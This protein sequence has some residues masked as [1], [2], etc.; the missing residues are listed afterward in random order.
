MNS[1][2]NFSY[3]GYFPSNIAVFQLVITIQKE[4]NPVS[5]TIVRPQDEILSRGKLGRL[6]NCYD[7]TP[8]EPYSAVYNMMAMPPMNII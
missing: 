5:K 2:G 3:R 6:Y 1:E 8:L 4:S 7:T